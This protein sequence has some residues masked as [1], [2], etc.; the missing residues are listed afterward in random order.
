[1]NLLSQLARERKWKYFE[2]RGRNSGVLTNPTVTY[3]GH[4]LDLRSKAEGLLTRFKSSVRRNVRKAK[5]SGLCVLATRCPEA[6]LDF[7]QLHGQT[8]KRHGLPPQ[9][10]SF[11]LNIREEIL[12]RGLGV[13]VIAK[14]GSH[15]VAAAVFF[16]FGEK[17]V[18]KFGASDESFCKLRCNNLVM[19]E[20]IRFLLEN[21][22]ETL[23]FGRT[24]L[25]NHGLRRFKLA[26]GTKEE[27]IEYFRFEP[28]TEKCLTGRDKTSGFHRTIF[29]RLP[30]AF[31]RLAGTIIYP[32]LD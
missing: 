26:W 12:E 19:F 28:L 29:S 8:R 18:Y 11:F 17:A 27:I 25:D 23:H 10:L 9:P 7:Y 24:S 21:G 2:V 13:V 22:V 14:S 32:H 30:L 20:A 3:F 31:N 15:P 5:Q 4:V 16:R 6:I 1:M